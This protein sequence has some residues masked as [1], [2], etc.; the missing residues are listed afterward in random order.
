MRSVFKGRGTSKEEKDVKAPHAQTGGTDGD[1]DD[2]DA[3][4]T[5]KKVVVA[6]F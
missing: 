3:D 2:V 4:P 1:G 6:Y 5:I